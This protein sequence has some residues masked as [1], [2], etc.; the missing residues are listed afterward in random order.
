MGTYRW[1]LNPG[2]AVV[3]APFKSNL[4]SQKGPP[5]PGAIVAAKRMLQD[6]N[7][8]PQ[9]ADRIPYVIIRGLP[10]S[11]LVERAVGPMEVLNDR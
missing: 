8:E 10:G 11:R 6:P 5:P 1:V 7:D 9:Y 3:L 2:L 4:D